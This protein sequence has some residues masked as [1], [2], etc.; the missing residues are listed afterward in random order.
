MWEGRWR[1]R[2]EG[3]VTEGLHEKWGSSEGLVEK[4]VGQNV[5]DFVEWGGYFPEPGEEMDW[6]ST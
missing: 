5:E 4:G 3:R 6:V 2:E 1:R